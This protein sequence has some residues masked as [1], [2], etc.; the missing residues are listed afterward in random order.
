MSSCINYICGRL[1]RYCNT[2]DKQKP[3]ASEFVN[4][5]NQKCPNTTL[6]NSILRAKSLDSAMLGIASS[7]TQSNET[8]ADKIIKG[9]K[10]ICVV[11]SAF[12]NM[13]VVVFPK[14]AVK[15]RDCMYY[16]HKDMEY[17]ILHDNVRYIGSYSFAQCNDLRCINIPEEVAHIGVYAFFSCSRLESLTMPEMVR[18]IGEYAFAEC[19]G[20][21]RIRLP[22]GLMRIEVSLFLECESLEEIEIPP[23]V[24]KIEDY[25]FMMCRS[26]HK[27]SMV[28]GNIREIGD[29]A[30]NNC[31]SLTTITIPEGVEKVGDY[32]FSDC[33]NLSLV[34]CPNMDIFG[35]NAFH[36]TAKEV[37]FM[38]AD[39]GNIR[40]Y[41]E[42]ETYLERLGINEGCKVM[43][44][45]WLEGESGR[46]MYNGGYVLK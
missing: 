29:S 36:N 35:Y 37:T 38:I 43:I 31:S 30:F 2:C 19:S 25:A 20:L 5:Y 27:V 21:R 13:K 32:A 14:S 3:T 26:L 44:N 23:K 9:E 41:S 40:Y 10:H 39:I 33:V 34:E 24:K 16:M 18:R 6:N 28:A 8:H 4:I 1:Q 42:M 17:M 45:H 22:S 46:I 7:V 15:V 12:S 11:R